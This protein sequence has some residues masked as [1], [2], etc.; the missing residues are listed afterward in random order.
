M[1]TKENLLSYMVFLFLLLPVA[2]LGCSGGGGDD[3]PAPRPIIKVL[4]SSYDF[5]VV[6][7]GNSPAALE[8]E[9]QNNGSLALTV[10]DITLADPSYVLNLNGGSNPCD[11]ASST[12]PARGNCTLEITFLPSVDGTFDGTLTI[13]SDDPDNPTLN[14][15]LSGIREPEL[16]LNVRINQVGSTNCSGIPVVTAYV[17]VTDQG[18]YPVITLSQDDFLIT[19]VGGYGGFPTEAPSFVSDVSETISVALVMDYSGT[20]VGSQDAVDDMEE[21]VA[22]FVANLGTDDEAEIIKFAT[23]IAVAQ[24]FTSNKTLLTDAINTSLDVG[25]HTALYDAV[26]KG[27]DDTDLRSKNRKAVIV[28]TDGVDDDGLGNPISSN[29]L[30]DAINYANSNG[31]PIFTVGMGSIID[32]AVLQ[33]MADDTGGQFY[34][35]INSDN[36]RNI[37]Q[38][39]ADILFNDQYILTYNSG[40]GIGVT[41]NLTIKATSATIE[42]SDT[43][44]ITV[45]P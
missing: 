26:V 19:E 8:V 21:S 31:I 28:I 12:I 2:F 10:S 30:N 40:L 15:P 33:Q 16:E 9:I 44:E 5:G 42:G 39:L 35:A 43:K 38:Q 37:Y 36:L 24:D 7:P 29:N 23:T 14:V 22:A 6:T 34:N 18:G 13:S 41:A 3:P 11:T 27:V 1:R 17:S 32:S 4:P 25:E 45:C 20:I